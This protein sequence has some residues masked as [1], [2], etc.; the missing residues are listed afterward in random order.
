MNHKRLLLIVVLRGKGGWLDSE[1]RKFQTV[2]QR[3]SLQVQDEDAVYRINMS[4]P[5]STEPSVTPS[6]VNNDWLDRLVP[7]NRHNFR[8]RKLNLVLSLAKWDQEKVI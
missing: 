8:P 5:N 3:D 1:A 6:E 4:L 2:D 7:E